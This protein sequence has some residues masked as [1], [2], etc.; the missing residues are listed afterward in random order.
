M[1]SS[2]QE[3]MEMSEMEEPK[4]SFELSVEIKYDDQF[5]E[6]ILVTAFEGGSN[7]WIDHIE[8]ITQAKKPKDAAR[9][10]WAFQVIKNGG[11]VGIYVINESGEPVDPNE[12]F[13]PLHIS[14]LI[15]GVQKFVKDAH[16][17][18]SLNCVGM[19]DSDL[20]LDAGN[21]DA[22]MADCVLQFALFGE[23]VYG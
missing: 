12:G 19:F 13:A 16:K 14:D 2:M 5:L 4:H 23:V 17:R 18:N 1:T 10:E 21:F 8:Y 6:D 7:Y 3:H 22:D 20:N 11:E 9:S 15:C